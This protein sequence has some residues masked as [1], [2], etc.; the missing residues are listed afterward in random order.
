M[1]IIKANWPAPA[2][3]S[4]VTTLRTGGF[5]QQYYAH[6]NMAYHVGDHEKDVLKNRERLKR[7]LYLPA[8]PTWLNQVHSNICIV[9]ETEEERTAD[10]A[11]SRSIGYPLAVMTADC[12]PITLCNLQGS[13]IAVIHAGWRGLVHHI[14]ENTLSK[15]TAKPHDIM[16]WVGPSICGNCF[17]VGEEVHQIYKENYPDSTQA[18]QGKQLKWLADLP[19]IAEMILNANGVKAV[20][21]AQRCTFELKNEY[22]SYRREQQ[23]GRMATLIWFNHA[24]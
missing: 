7:T 20:Y 18:F 17:E 3:I 19:L 10:A 5:S 23:T 9:A 13:E 14:I 2:N 24:I 22:Y 21:K 12:L 15:M 1:D 11:I 6:N 4:A 16:A 8:E